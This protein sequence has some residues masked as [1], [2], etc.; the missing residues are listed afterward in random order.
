MAANAKARSPPALALALALASWPPRRAAFFGGQSEGLPPPA[1]L[2]P[3]THLSAVGKPLPDSPSVALLLAIGKALNNRTQ[4]DTNGQRPTPDARHTAVL[5]PQMRAY[6]QMPCK[7]NPTPT[8]KA[9]S[10]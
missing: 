8:P 5:C 4:P 1:T 10:L 6:S 2:V 7:E 3:R 9:E